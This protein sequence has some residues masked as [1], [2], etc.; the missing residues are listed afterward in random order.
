LSLLRG[1][2]LRF[3]LARA[4]DIHARE[5]AAAPAG[6]IALHATVMTEAI[7]NISHAQRSAS[8]ARAGH[9]RSRS[10]GQMMCGFD[11][12]LEGGFGSIR[13]MPAPWIIVFFDDDGRLKEVTPRAAKRRERSTQLCVLMYFSSVARPSRTIKIFFAVFISLRNQF[14]SRL[15][16]TAL[17]TRAPSKLRASFSQ[18]FERVR[19]APALCSGE[20][21]NR[22]ACGKVAQHVM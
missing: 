18:L 16:I 7:F 21:P 5:S 19:A 11:P 17:A 10:Q 9:A 14:K 8:A 2:E 22:S 6:N 15:F 4:P 20:A 3:Y 1:A 12:L 13:H